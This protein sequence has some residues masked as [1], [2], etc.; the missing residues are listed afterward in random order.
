MPISFIPYKKE[1]QEQMRILVALLGGK[2]HPENGLPGRP[3]SPYPRLTGLFQNLPVEIRIV[4]EPTRDGA[5]PLNTT[6]YLD[7]SLQSPCALSLDVESKGRWWRLQ[8]LLWWRHIVSAEKT[9]DQNYV[10]SSVEPRRARRLLARKKI[11]NQLVQVLPFH[12]L[13]LSEKHLRFRR[14]VDSHQV[15]MARQVADILRRLL[16]LSR[17]CQNLA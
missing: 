16:R 13:Q 3:A 1:Y 6:K 14:T 7:I 9:L 12:S 15:F 4:E 8:K 5:D 2:L 17:L 11:R 10:F